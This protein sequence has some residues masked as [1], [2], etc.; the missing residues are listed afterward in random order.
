[1]V[2]NFMKILNKL[3]EFIP[4]S[5]LG[6]VVLLVLLIICFLKAL[7]I[8][9]VCVPTSSM[10]PTIKPGD[11]VLVANKFFCMPVKRNEIVTFKPNPQ[12]VQQEEERGYGD[13]DFIKRVIGLPGD[14]INIKDGVVYVNGEKLVQ[15]YKTTPS[16]YSCYFVVPKGKLFLLGDNRGDSDDSHMWRNPFISENKVVGIELCVL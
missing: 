2:D 1:M 3:K 7:V 12:Q 4:S 11:Y 10:Y 8:Y 14:R 15:N 5:T 13:S 16:H 6:K 9:P